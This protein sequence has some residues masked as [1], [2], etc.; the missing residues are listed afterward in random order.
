MKACIQVFTCL[1]LLLS[2][3]HVFAQS[4]LLIGEIVSKKD[5]AKLIGVHVVNINSNKATNSTADGSFTIPYQNGDTL[6]LTSIGYK[7]HI[8]YTSMFWLPSGKAITIY[9]SERVYNLPGYDVNQY[10]TKEEFKEDFINQTPIEPINSELFEYKKPSKLE[11]VETDLNAHIP[12]TSPISL[13]YNKWGREARQARKLAKA[14]EKSEEEKIIGE[15]YNPQVVQKALELD[16][17]E[18]AQRFMEECPLEDEFVLKAKE[19]DII[20]AILDC[21]KNSSITK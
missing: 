1:L 9:M 19:Y 18:E 3:N 6:I 15:K 14:K 17:K 10:S 7:D 20:K 4:K 16:S 2:A 12:I 13:F 21:Q 5:S 11:D 8:L